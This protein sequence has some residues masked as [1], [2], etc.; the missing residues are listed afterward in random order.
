MDISTRYMGFELRNPIIVASSGLTATAEGVADC[1][2]HGAAAV[3]LKSLFEEQIL[4]NYEAR[5]NEVKLETSYPEAEEYI[6]LHTRSQAVEEY[7]GLI[8]SCKKT[9]NIPVVASINCISASEW[10]GFAKEIQLAGADALELNLSILPSDTTKTCGQIE[11]TYIDILN[12]VVKNLTIPVSIKISSYFSGLA[13]TAL[14]FSFTGIRGMVLF[15]RFYTPDIDIEEFKIIPG[16][17]YSSP[18][19]LTVPLRWIAIL[20]ER[21]YCDLAA[22]TGVHDGTGLVKVLLAGAKAAQ[23]CSVL[24]D[25][26]L[27]QIA[28]MLRYLEDYLKRH[29]FGSVQEI[30]GKM[31]MRQTENPAAYER[32]QFMKHY[33]EIE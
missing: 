22:S 20:S 29:R 31:S 28:P 15:N 32:V 19:E 17:I 33:S 11:E 7:V 5:L 3:V 25:K 9:V 18:S 21:I 14:R 10:T 27:G 4:F 12:E 2:K 16:S 13:K 8:R 1:E 30:I 24:Y 26:G 6:N 23:V